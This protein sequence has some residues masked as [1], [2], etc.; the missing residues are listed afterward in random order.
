MALSSD[1]PAPV[2]ASRRT[3]GSGIPLYLGA[4]RSLKPKNLPVLRLSRRSV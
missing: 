4:F 1:G 2:G 3:V